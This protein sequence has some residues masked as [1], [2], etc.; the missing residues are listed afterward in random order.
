MKIIPAK[1]F[2]VRV[3]HYCN[4]Y[5]I[6]EYS[7]ARFFKKWKTLKKFTI[8]NFKDCE[9]VPDIF[10]SFKY[11]EDY[12]KT[13]ESIDDVDSYNKREKDKET[14]FFLRK[15]EWMMNI[16]PYSHKIIKCK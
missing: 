2:C 16:R 10:E 6:I 1:K 4:S 11:A 15:N 9:W 14:E 12:A 13:L 3:S 7:Y 5:Y 8:Y